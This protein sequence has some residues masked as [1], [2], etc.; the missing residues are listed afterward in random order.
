MK[1]TNAFLT[2]LAAAAAAAAPVS[3][4][5]ISPKVVYP[6]TGTVWH[7]HEQHHVK[8]IVP[9]DARGARGT[10]LLGHLDNNSEHLDNAHPLAT[11]IDFETG[12]VEITVPSVPAGDHY[13]VALLGDSGNISEEFKILSFS[14]AEYS[15]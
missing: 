9:K 1:L 10:L 4:I 11:N 5:V 12:Q 6:H 15:K 2:L 7:P 8:W 14:A 13:I 3:D